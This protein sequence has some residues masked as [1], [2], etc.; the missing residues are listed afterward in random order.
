MHH[1]VFDYILLITVISWGISAV[2]GVVIM[3]IIFN[4]FVIPK[5][6][7]KVMCKLK[8]RPIYNYFL[9]GNFTFKYIDVVGHLAW[10]YL[11]WKIKGNSE[12]VKMSADY[13]L[14][15]VNY[16]IENASKF[17]LLMTLLACANFLIAI[18]SMLIAFFIQMYE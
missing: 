10:K 14:G 15:R 7:K 3:P 12:V 5:I 1:S 11:A 18:I 13:G 17:E 4:C 16:R 9:F 8:T 2:I 6:E